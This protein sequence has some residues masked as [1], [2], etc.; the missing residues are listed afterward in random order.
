[1]IPYFYQ[2]DTPILTQEEKHDLIELASLH[3]NDFKSYVSANGV[4]DGNQ[5]WRDVDLYEKAFIKRLVENCSL[6]CV[7]VLVRHQPG[8]K[9]LKHIDDPNKRNTVLSMP[10]TPKEEYSPTYFF[11]NQQDSRP[12]AIARFTNLNAC[13]LN[14]QQ[15]H[16]LINQSSQ[17]RINLQLM[18]NDSFDEVHRLIIDK[19]LF[20]KNSKILL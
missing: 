17:I 5:I 1:M 12:V 2:L 9:V 8:A 10:L 11:S 20:S 6:P 3:N 13:L 18:F 7:P 16:G 15:V 14:T 4:V 19:Q